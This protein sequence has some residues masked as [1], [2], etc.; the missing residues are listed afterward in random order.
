MLDLGAEIYQS[1]QE[2]QTNNLS[3]KQAV[4]P[5]F[6]QDKQQKKWIAHTGLNGVYNLF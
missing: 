6:I 4:S 2:I 5:V 3:V 1:P